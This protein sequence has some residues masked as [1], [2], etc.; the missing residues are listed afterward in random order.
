MTNMSDDDPP[1]RSESVPAGAASMPYRLPGVVS[2][3]SDLPESTAADR[4]L[5]PGSTKICPAAATCGPMSAERP[6]GAPAMAYVKQIPEGMPVGIPDGGC[7][8][9]DVTTTLPAS[10]TRIT[11]TDCGGIV[12][13]STDDGDAEGIGRITGDPPPSAGIRSTS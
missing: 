9:P 2:D 1:A 12:S 7:C 4:F 5:L 13:R 6:S 11:G 8:S 10:E 3:D